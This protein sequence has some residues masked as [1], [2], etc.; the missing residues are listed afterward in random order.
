MVFLVMILMIL[1]GKKNDIKRQVFLDEFK[2]RNFY[3][4][5]NTGLFKF[6]QVTIE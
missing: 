5:L 3:Y 4:Y 1:Y 2:M 6:H